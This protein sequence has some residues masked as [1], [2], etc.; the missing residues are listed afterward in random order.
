MQFFE[1]QAGAS[2]AAA[3]IRLQLAAADTGQALSGLTEATVGLVAEFMREDA[4]V[5]T[6]IDLA[7][8]GVTL[9]GV[10][11]PEAGLYDF[12]GPAAMTV[13]SAGVSFVDVV[14]RGA[15]ILVDPVRV[16]LRGYDPKVAPPDNASIAA[17][18]DSVLADNFAAIATGTPPSASAVSAQ[19]L[20][21]LAGTPGV[22]AR[23]AIGAAV[24]AA[25]ADNFAAIPAAVDAVLADNFAA[26]ATGTPPSAS[27]VSAQVLADLAGAPG[28]TARTAIGV[29]VDAAVADNFT[30]LPAAIRDALLRLRT[31]VQS[32]PTGGSSQG[33]AIVDPVGGVMLGTVNVIR[34]PNGRIVGFS[35]PL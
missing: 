34:D 10:G 28:A 3:K 35:E 26:I 25:V 19:V 16:M 20:A 7:A 23:T 30:S 17:A 27:A 1:I 5:A 31:G 13:N 29:A 4:V 22:T 24:D 33:L 2:G 21:D 11:S 14:L 6:A 8:S 12:T 32:I 18:V 9:I 15:N